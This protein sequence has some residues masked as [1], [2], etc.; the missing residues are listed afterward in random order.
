LAL[1]LLTLR[2]LTLLL[3]HGRLLALLLARGGAGLLLDG[4][5]RHGFLPYVVGRPVDPNSSMLS[6]CCAVVKAAPWQNGGDLCP[7][8]G[9]CKPL[10]RETDELCANV[11]AKAKGWLKTA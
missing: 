7:P 9:S 11:I 1:L 3:S 4:R 2:G 10:F 6:C 5:G 8:F